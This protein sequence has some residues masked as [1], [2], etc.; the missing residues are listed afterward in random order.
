MTKQVSKSF[1]YG[2]SVTATLTFLYNTSK[3]TFPHFIPSFEG[4]L[5]GVCKQRSDQTPLPCCLVT[6]IKRDQQQR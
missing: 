2:I 6:W 1:V 3:N 5:G 4:E